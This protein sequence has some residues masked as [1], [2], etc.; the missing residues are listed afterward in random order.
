M[1]RQILIITKDPYLGQK[2]NIELSESGAAVRISADFQAESVK[3][4]GFVFLDTEASDERP[5]GN[6]FIYLCRGNEPIPNGSRR[7]SVPFAIGDAVAQ[8]SKIPDS[9][10]LFFDKKAKTAV[11]YGKS[12]RLTDVEAALFGVLLEAEG[13]FVSREELLD[14]VWRGEKQSGVLNVYIHYLREKLELKGE[15][16]L[17]SS[18]QKGYAVEPRFIGRE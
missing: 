8:L 16:I 5:N 15:K 9:P 11:V 6:R 14:R 3:R 13:N 7:L 12:V 10:R 2:L 18:R 4:A 1:E 17:L